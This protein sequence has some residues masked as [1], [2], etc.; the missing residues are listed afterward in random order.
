MSLRGRI[1]VALFAASLFMVPGTSDAAPILI[2][3]NASGC[4]GS[5]CIPSQTASLL[6]GLIEYESNAFQDFI[7]MTAADGTLAINLGTGNFGQLQVN[8]ANPFTLVNTPFSLLLGFS[9]PNTPN[10]VFSAS[11]QGI[12]SSASSGGIVLTF[13]PSAVSLPFTNGGQSGILNIFA[14]STA[15]PSGGSGNING[16]IIASVPEPSSLMLWGVGS[17]GLAAFKRRAA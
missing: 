16:Y 13:N 7:G 5:G 4:F 11:I 6:G 14:F 1:Q 9:S 2:A 3:G 8:T 15:V 12:V 17:L 10:A